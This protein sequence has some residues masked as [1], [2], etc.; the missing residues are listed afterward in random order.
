MEQ[1]GKVVSTEEGYAVVELIRESACSSC[2]HKD[3]CGA[4]VMA[5][6]GKSEK[7]T[8]KVNDPFGVKAG[9][10]VILGSDSAS[11]LGIAFCVFI[12]PLLLTFAAYMLCDRFFGNNAVSVIVTAA[13]FFGFDRA[14]KGKVR[15]SITDVTCEKTDG[16]TE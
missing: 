11:T 9:D 16:V 4:N 10:T 15:I 5:G 8:V 2:H 1:M 14:L 6:C 12:L 3:S 7:V 13:V